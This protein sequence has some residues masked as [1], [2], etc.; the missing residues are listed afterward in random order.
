MFE[1]P[2]SHD[3]D[4]DKFERLGKLLGVNTNE[5]GVRGIGNVRQLVPAIA[6]G[7]PTGQVQGFQHW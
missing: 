2:I 6:V 3:D 1:I 7:L 4:D 5:L